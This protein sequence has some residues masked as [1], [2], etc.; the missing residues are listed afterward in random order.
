M[1]IKVKLF[2][3]GAKSYQEGNN[4][5][6]TLKGYVD[7]L[8]QFEGYGS[9]TRSRFDAKS[10]KVAI[11]DKSLT[12]SQVDMILRTKDYAESQHIGFTISIV[13]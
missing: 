6:N 10:L 8:T 13:K 12:K 11:P 9:V 2:D 1:S 7:K 5:Y 4:L 3:T